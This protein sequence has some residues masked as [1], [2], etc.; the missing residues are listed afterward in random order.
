MQI[1]TYRQS[2]TENLKYFE[3][4]LQ[5]TAYP[6][7]QQKSQYTLASNS[8]S[9]KLDSR[10]KEKAKNIYASK[11]A[12]QRWAKIPVSERAKQVP[13]TG[14]RPRKYPQCPRYGSHRFSPKTGR[15]PC[16]FS[17]PSK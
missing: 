8:P 5:A 17:R 1:V 11:L 15:C 14:G 2:R 3:A 4:Q 10:M 7:E 9:L 6:N 16:G 12:H 13:R